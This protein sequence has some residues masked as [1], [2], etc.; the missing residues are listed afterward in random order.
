MWFETTVATWIPFH[1]LSAT[2]FSKV[3]LFLADL[4]GSLRSFLEVYPP[5]CFSLTAGG[6]VTKATGFYEV[7]VMKLQEY[8]RELKPELEKLVI[9]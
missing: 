3:V 7:T 4:S 2:E 1:S 5:A 9:S 8:W 6:F